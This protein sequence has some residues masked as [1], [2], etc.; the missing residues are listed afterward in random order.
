MNENKDKGILEQK[1]EQLWDAVLVDKGLI[2]NHLPHIDARL[3]K[4]ELRMAYYIGGLAVLSFLAPFI[5][6]MVFG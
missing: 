3:R 5:I 1:V 2:N 6:K 4:I